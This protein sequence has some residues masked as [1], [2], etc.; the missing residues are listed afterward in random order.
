MY[1]FNNHSEKNDAKLTFLL[2]VFYI[3]F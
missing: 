2:D 1:L 3:I